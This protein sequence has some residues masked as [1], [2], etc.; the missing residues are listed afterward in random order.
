MKILSCGAGMQSTALALMACEQ[1]ITCTSL[2]PDVPIYD[3][4]IFCDLGL[5]PV[6]VKQQV[7][8]IL[9]VCEEAGIPF[10]IL[11]AP[12][13]QDFLRN[14]G[15]RRTVSIPWWTLMEDG[16]K[17]K[18]PRNCTIDDKVELVAKFIRWELLGYKKGQRLRPE[19]VKAHELHMGF[20]AEEKRRCKENPNRL[21]VNKFP[22]VKMGLTRADN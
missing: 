16:H 7:E 2:Y 11:D 20:S 18:M 21:F 1:A 19:D 6:W 9:C 3:A 5:E 10:Y 8:F 4:I 14:F 12:L 22:L 15:Q 13:Y 17:S